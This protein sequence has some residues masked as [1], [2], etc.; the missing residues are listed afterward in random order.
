MS[1][2]LVCGG[3][4]LYKTFTPTVNQ[5]GGLIMIWEY[6]SAVALLHRIE[7]HMDRFI[8]RDIL[9]NFFPDFEE[10]MPLSNMF[11]HDNNPKIL[12]DVIRVLSS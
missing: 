10:T 6:S 4:R 8:Y 3:T 2:H 12:L 9:N 11:Q 1:P 5:N 7:E